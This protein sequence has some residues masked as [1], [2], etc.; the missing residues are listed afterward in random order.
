[1]E[2]II[3][4]VNEEVFMEKNS[5][6]QQALE[7]LRE[8]LQGAKDTNSL[9]SIGKHLPIEQLT[10]LREL[11]YQEFR[12]KLPAVLV[13]LPAPQFTHLLQNVAE[14]DLQSFKDLA[15]TEPMQHHLT[16]LSH[17]LQH[18]LASQAQEIENLSREISQ[19]DIAT[20]DNED[21]LLLEKKIDEIR[22]ALEELSS[23]NNKAL[24]IAW[25]TARPD[26]IETFSHVR[27]RSETLLSKEVG[28]IRNGSN[29]PT[30]LYEYLENHLFK[31]YTSGAPFE[32]LTDEEPA[33]E[34]LAKFSVWYPEDYGSIGLLHTPSGNSGA[35]PHQQDQLLKEVNE[36]LMSVGLKTVADLKKARIF[37]KKTLQ[38]YIRKKQGTKA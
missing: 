7:K 23:L 29:S 32:S 13:G 14:T 15:Q 11:L 30:G 12:A 8:A 38:E 28:R 20:L 33:I 16:V 3:K 19:I 22:Q 34:A 27:E 9:E 4:L 37:S 10:S 26:L 17:E 18:R 5:N 2:Y 25:N 36:S 21:T 6:S 24:A 31:V 1:M 35:D